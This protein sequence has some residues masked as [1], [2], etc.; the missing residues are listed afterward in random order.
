MILVPVKILSNA[1]QRLAPLLDQ[2]TRTQLAQ[3]MLADVLEAVAIYGREA[4]AVV[5]SDGFA[6]QLARQQG[7]EIIADDSNRSETDAIEMA[8]GVCEARGIA[9]T[10]V[11]PGDI[12][13]IEAADLA[14]IFSHAPQRGSVLVPA[15]DGRGTNAALRTPAGL[16]PLRFGNDSFAPHANSA[17]ATGDP[18]VILQLRRVALDIDSPDDLRQLAREPGSKRSQLLARRLLSDRE[19]P[20]QAVS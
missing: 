11:I 3:A 4:A 15:A 6:A 5:T 8:T 16:F 18:C 17:K 9:T 7:L 13:L 19:Q 10:L 2:S 14:A 20:A 12:P 1:K